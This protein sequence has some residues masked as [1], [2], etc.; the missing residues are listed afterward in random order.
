MK[1]DQRLLA[2]QLGTVKQYFMILKSLISFTW[3]EG[4]PI[5]QITLA[6][7]GA[8]L[9]IVWRYQG[10]GQIRLIM[11]LGQLLMREIQIVL[12]DKAPVKTLPLLVK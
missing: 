5:F 12:I 8:E 1:L 9:Y 2:K 6:G 11:L 10:L 3:N 4:M 7:S